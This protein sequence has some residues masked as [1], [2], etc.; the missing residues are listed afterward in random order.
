MEEC[1]RIL[2]G[3]GTTA[4]DAE[5]IKG[6][7]RAGFD[8]YNVYPESVQRIEESII[9]MAMS[10]G[11]KVL[12][13][14]GDG[15]LYQ[16]LSG[17]EIDLGNNKV[18]ICCLS[19]DNSRVI[20]KAIPFTNPVSHRGMPVTIGLGDRL[21]IASPGHIR[22]IRRY[23][24]FPVLAQQSIREL[25]LTGRTYEDVL[26]AASWAVLQE[27]Y[28]SGFGADGDHLKTPQEVKMALECG[29]TMITLDCSDYIDN[30]IAALEQPYID[31]LYSSIPAIEKS[32][33]EAKYLNREFKLDKGFII[34][35]SESE[36]KRTVL[37]YYK[38][39]SYI[40]SIYNEIIKSYEKTV[41]FEISID[42]T[43]TPTTPE[44]H[45]F[46]ASELKDEGV[47]VTSL[48]PRFCG[49][50]QKGIDYR[51]DK[52]QFSIEFELHAEI[53]RKFGYKISIHSGS[54]KFGIFPIVGE[55]TGRV[56][57]L[58][59]A[60]TS[61]LEA[62]RVIAQYKPNL[63]RRMHSIALTRLEDAKKYYHISTDAAK[64]PGIDT[65]KDEDLPGLMDNDECRQLLHIT[66][67]FILAD[68]K[69]VGRNG[70]RDELYEFLNSFENEYYNALE[71]HIGKHLDLLG[72]RK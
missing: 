25:T 24:L 35:F 41:D 33:L 5:N 54:D 57:H 22:A 29:F 43:L 55:K 58:K 40:K 11:E 26:A 9:Y 49:E 31:K 56:F 52:Q 34:K 1:I 17:E 47:E 10:K 64:I 48:A 27:G 60:G 28:T 72:L 70:L 39:I 66:Y 62:V 30:S 12:V 3:L 7:A 46:T 38:T 37:I 51:G 23:N 44:S 18:K 21:G 20:R 53:A 71:K 42:E 68:K 13:V 50:F 14:Y 63:Y 19:I 15:G 67:G 65:I 59:T 16:E 69:A 2:S 6:L 32:R 45:Y 36:F 4:E 61:W 8:K